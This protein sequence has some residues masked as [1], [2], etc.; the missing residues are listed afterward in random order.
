MLFVIATL[1]IEPGS[2]DAVIT[3]VKPC[4]EATRREQGCISY[5]LHVAV[6]DDTK[7][8]FV[9]RWENR[10]ALEAHFETPH[11]QKWREEGGKYFT[12][13]KI[14]IIEDGKVEVL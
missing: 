8:V 6:D 2:L 4:L 9:E 13:R 1:T 3:A 10:K 7:L 5:D 11:L 12:G 14:E